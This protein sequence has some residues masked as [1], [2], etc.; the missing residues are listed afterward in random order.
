VTVSVSK[1]PDLVPVPDVRGH[2]VDEA[3]SMLSQ[4]GLS[5]ANV[6]GPSKR[7]TVF[8]TDPPAG[9]RVHRGSGVNLYTI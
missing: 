8:F 6:Y 2:S 4:A 3:T 1:G 7:G 9:Q 5:V